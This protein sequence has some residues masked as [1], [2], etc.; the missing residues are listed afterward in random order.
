VPEPL[1]EVTDL[2]VEYLTEAGDVRAVDGVTFSVD[3]GEF[4]GIVGESGCG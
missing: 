2:S 4:L 1:L 3:P